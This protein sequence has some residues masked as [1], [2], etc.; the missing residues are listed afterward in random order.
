MRMLLGLV[1]GGSLVAATPSIADAC[2]APACWPGAMTPT[3]G[4]TV[5]S[6]LPGI[7]WRPQNAGTDSA[8]DPSL[9]V[10]ATAADPGTP[11]PVTATAV[12]GGAFVLV[13][14]QPLS[15]N[16]AYVV[17]DHNTCADTVGTMGPTTSFQVGPPAPLPTVLGTL[18][19]TS[20]AIEMIDVATT[21][22]SCSASILAHRVGI[23]P[24]LIFEATPWTDVFHFETYVDGA[25]W[26]RTESLP[27][28][29]SVR[30]TW[31]LY[32][33]C[34]SD[35]PLASAGLAAGPHTVTVKATI[36]GTSVVLSSEPLT[37]ALDCPGEAPGDHGGD[38]AGGGADGGCQA[39]G[40]SA[41]LWFVL[42]T[43]GLVARQRRGRLR[44]CPHIT[45][46]RTSST[47]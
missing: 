30:G 17:T 5:P 41:P 31:Q 19:I 42:G 45:V 33:T 8:S 28:P 26:Q 24:A 6:N 7:F 44:A 21:S 47:Q 20:D 4:S 37:V 25:L 2:S 16:T 32:R 23:T 15:E 34:E 13:P 9:V 38:N 14:T 11:L 3:A 22:G 46:R 36:P 1:A 12:G 40:S 27:T 29:I 35:D 39:G 10:L 43:L 18:E